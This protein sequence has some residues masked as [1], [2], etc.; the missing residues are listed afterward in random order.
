M[1]ARKEVEVLD[2]W[3]VVCVDGLNWQVHQFAEVK[4]ANGTTAMEWKAL[5]S[6]HGT[7]ESAVKAIWR[8]LPKNMKEERKTLSQACKTL[9]ELSDK[10]AES[11]RKFNEGVRA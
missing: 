9:E 1:G 10:V 6:Y 2:D 8:K 3:K 5:P 7:L 4:K 11:A